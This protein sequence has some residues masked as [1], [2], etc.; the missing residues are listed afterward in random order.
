MAM[1]DPEQERQRLAEFYSQQMDGELEK[2]AEQAY[3]LTDLARQ[4]LRAEMSR[5][6]LSARLD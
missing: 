4:A 2:V 1:I 3:E 6:G 5:R